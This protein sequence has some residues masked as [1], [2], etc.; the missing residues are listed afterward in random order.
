MVRV[1][2]V[3][4]LLLAF[5]APAAAQASR[6]VEA[7]LFAEHE[8]VV[9]GQ[10][11]TIALEEKIRSGWHTYWINPGDA[12][13]PTNIQWSLPSG[14]RIGAIQWPT[15]KRIPIAHLMDYGYED[16]VWLLMDATVPADAK[17]GEVVTLQ[18]KADWLVCKEVCVPEEANLSLTFRI[19]A[20]PAKADFAHEREF[21]EAR[22]KLPVKSPWKISYA[23]GDVLD[24]YVAAPELSQAKPVD[25]VFFPR[26][27]GLIKGA[28]PQRLGYA[29]S[30]LVLRLV[31]GKNI[32]TLT[33][34]FE[35][36]L[37]LTSADAS[38]Q[39][40]QV[41]ALP[42]AIPT[43]DFTEGPGLGLAL[44]LFFA[45]LG[46]L[47][48]NVMPCVLPVLALKALALVNANTA[49]AR[50]EGASYAAGVLATFTALGVVIVLLRQSGAI[51]GWGF[52]LQEPLVV[53]GFALLMFAIGLNLSG[54][55]VLEP[56]T[57]GNTLASKGGAAGAFFTGV[58]AV[59]IAAPCTAPF[60]AAA[61]GYALTQT[62]PMAMAVFLALGLGFAAPFLLLSLWPAA[63][64]AL[65]RPGVWMLRL[66]H[67]LAVPMYG[68]ALWLAWVLSQQ[69][70]RSGLL[71]FVVAALV[72]AAGALAWTMTRR[73]DPK[74]R[75]IGALTTLAT[76]LIALSCLYG[77][78]TNAAPS[79]A[80]VREDAY[81]AQKLAALRAEGRP[82]F[83]N[84]T[85]AWCITC[86]VN[87]QVV[88]S[89]PAV[90]RM[91][92]DKKVALLVADWT[93]RNAEITQLLRQHGRS[94]V[95][96]YLYYAAGSSTPVVL[97]QILTEQNIAAALNQ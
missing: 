8:T 75:N 28:E 1:L 21:S 11:V 80:S 38:K 82:V 65:P 85:A 27:S 72:I 5:G 84:A 3:L 25:A 60:M 55:F 14:W 49:K 6:N 53:A 43:V 74:G 13:A 76:L 12:G 71:L 36:V 96:L 54:V 24:L 47:I 81:T 29:D 58:L 88:L 22:S 50:V 20:P 18:G 17:P 97:P 16:K 34:A 10:R 70:N 41:N 46:G 26:S 90:Q 64:R 39:A 15:P 93:N 69:V 83:V 52:Q 57:T 66:K 94:G 92:T 63:I 73:L 45:F 86:L 62:T 48:L 78:K 30:G 7:R 33:G 4:A 35:G 23:K 42:G 51:L 77:L 95:P 44:A 19:V 56:V 59:A 79:S 40:L 9:P 87:E 61:L 31:P 91:F 68:A 2:T 32:R 67:I 89:R 37:V